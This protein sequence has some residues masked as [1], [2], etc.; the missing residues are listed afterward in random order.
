MNK[1]ILI[2]LV[3]SL[4]ACKQKSSFQNS[5]DFVYHNNPEALRRASNNHPLSTLN[6]EG[7]IDILWIIDNSG[8]MES[9]QNNVI[10]NTKIFMEEFVKQ[11]YIKWKMGLISTDKRDRPRIGFDV[12]FDST[13]IDHSD[14]T[15][16]DQV[17]NKFQN[18][19]SYLGTNGD[20]SE[21]EF[22][23]IL[24]LIKEYDANIPFIRRNSHLAVIMVTDEKEQSEEFGAQYQALTFL[25]TIRAFVNPQRQIRFY[26]AF[27]FK[28]L[29]DCNSSWGYTFAG[30]NFEKI[31]TETG[32]FHISACVPDFGKKLVEVGKDI[33]SLAGRPSLLLKDRPKVETL[34]VY[35]E[36]MLLAPGKQE[37][38][39]YWYYEETYNT[40]NFYTLEFVD[41]IEKASFRVKY[42]I[43]DGI[44]DRPPRSK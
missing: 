36:N 31:I 40:I 44:D 2:I 37:D 24:R 22:Y 43:D 15:S 35:Y 30:S 4:N 21:Y 7:E 42:D 23:N 41:D 32:G 25:N 13:L 14:P 19:V 39:G 28:D 8:S 20:A 10:D 17:V 26:G 33:A 16:L 6:V 34:K 18:A 12:P 29:K 11:K 38:G 9:I 27:D 5:E 1:L 3:L